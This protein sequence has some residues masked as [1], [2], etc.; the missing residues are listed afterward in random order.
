MFQ[1]FLCLRLPETFR[2]ERPLPPIDRLPG[3]IPTFVP[4][5]LGLFGERR[6]SMRNPLVP[7]TAGHVNHITSQLPGVC[8]YSAT[9]PISD[10]RARR[11]RS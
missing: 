6:S 11:L 2:S 1:L 4:Q 8:L 10:S 3:V 9:V 5:K 7:D